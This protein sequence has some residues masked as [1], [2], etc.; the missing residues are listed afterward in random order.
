[1]LR[2]SAIVPVLRLRHATTLDCPARPPATPRSRA[3]RWRWERCEWD[4]PAAAPG[5]RTQDGVI[6]APTSLHRPDTVDPETPA[7]SAQCGGPELRAPT[8]Q[9]RFRSL[10]VV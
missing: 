9:P 7:H 1:M 3:G 6:T 8:P 10:A 5:L 2:G 4:A